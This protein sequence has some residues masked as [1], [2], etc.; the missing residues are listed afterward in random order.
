[1]EV[2]VRVRKARRNQQELGQLIIPG[3][4][5]SFRA[6]IEDTSEW[7]EVLIGP[8]S[9]TGIPAFLAENWK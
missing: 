8:E 6:E 9:A 5:P 3:L 1:M 7:K 4:I 2:T